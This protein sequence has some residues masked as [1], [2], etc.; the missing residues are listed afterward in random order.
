MQIILG[1]EDQDHREKGEESRKLIYCWRKG[2]DSSTDAE[3]IAD[4][5]G[6]QVAAWQKL[7]QYFDLFI[8]SPFTMKNIVNY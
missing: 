1:Q 3:K 6:N 2:E 4:T 7:D 8:W 5:A